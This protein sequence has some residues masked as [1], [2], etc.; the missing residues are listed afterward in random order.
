[1]KTFSALS[2]LT[3][4]LLAGCGEKSSSPAQPTNAPA[5]SSGSPLTAP[6]DYLG[7][8]GNAQK[9]AEKTI[10]TASIQHALQMYQID[11]GHYPKELKELVDEGFMPKLPQAPY[12]M[13]IVYNAQDG[14]VK[15]VKQ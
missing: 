1:M 12:G 10:D 15:V 2:L 11:K 4:G 13:K 9:T 3:V 8:V 7:A 14:S 6:V 5:A